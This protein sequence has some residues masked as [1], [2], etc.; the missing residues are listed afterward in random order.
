ML[1]LLYVKVGGYCLDA[2]EKRLI[3]LVSAVGFSVASITLDL[4]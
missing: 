4:V 3:L 1:S 2:D